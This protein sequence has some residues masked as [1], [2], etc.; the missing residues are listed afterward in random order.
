ME[1]LSLLPHQLRQALHRAAVE[2][3]LVLEGLDPVLEEPPREPQAA[4]LGFE[5][6]IHGLFVGF[7]GE[8]VQLLG[9]IPGPPDV[10]LIHHRPPLAGTRMITPTGARVGTPPSSSFASHLGR[11]RVEPGRSGLLA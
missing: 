3:S 1:D 4:L 6:L 5:G 10:L 8:L 11:G 7:A 2:L 9:G